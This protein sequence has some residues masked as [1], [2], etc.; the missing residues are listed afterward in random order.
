ML[1]NR[2]NGKVVN[3]PYVASARDEPSQLAKGDSSPVMT[4]P[5]HRCEGAAVC[6]VRKERD[7]G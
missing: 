5:D 2:L 4:G 6:G 3:R 7:L 1:L